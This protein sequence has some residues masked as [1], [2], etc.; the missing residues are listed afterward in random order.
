MISIRALA[1]NIEFETSRRAPC[2][3]A[4]YPIGG[5]GFQHGRKV[6]R[7]LATKTCQSLIHTGTTEVCVISF[8]IGLDR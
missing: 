2:R 6:S 3:S 7:G 1:L 5:H 4:N 8:R